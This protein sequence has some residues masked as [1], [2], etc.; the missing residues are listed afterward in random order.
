MRAIR[1]QLKKIEGYPSTQPWVSFKRVS[2]IS[3]LRSPHRTLKDALRHDLLILKSQL[4]NLNK[5]AK[6]LQQTAVRQR[7]VEARANF[8]SM[9]YRTLKEAEKQGYLDQG[10]QDALIKESERVLGMFVGILVTNPSGK[11][12]GA[13]LKQLEDTLLLGGDSSGGACHR[14]FQA[15]TIAGGKLD[16]KAET[17]FRKNPKVENFVKL[18]HARESDMLLGG[19]IKWKPDGWRPAKPGTVHVV[20]KGDTLSGISQRYYGSPGYW[21]VIYLEN[22]QIIVDDP[23]DLKVGWNLKIP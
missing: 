2:K 11:N 20:A 5:Q 4:R 10:R 13:V 21:D 3:D 7:A 17:A 8:R 23:D 14:A 6:Q 22:S 19:N 16:T 18:L 15:L 1:E 12:I 9:A